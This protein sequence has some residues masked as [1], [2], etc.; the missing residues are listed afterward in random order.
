MAAVQHFRSALNGFNRQDVVQYIEF[1]NNQHNAKV[2]QL[3]TQ[4][5]NAQDALMEFKN[6]AIPAA[7]TEE[8]EALRQ[9]CAALEEELALCKA[10]VPE[11]AELET[12]RRAER[13]ERL[14]QER[15]NQIYAQANALLAEATASVDTAVQQMTAQLQSCI[16]CADSA[17]TMLQDAANA[18]YAIRPE[19]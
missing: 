11:N 2:Q 4:L 17:K 14:A 3:N 7:D 5:K 8:L 6:V 1:L 16:S 9:R 18:M 13:A 15:A 10:A 12:Y 19:E